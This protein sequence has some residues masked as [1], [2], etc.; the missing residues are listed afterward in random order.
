MYFDVA[1]VGGGAA[2]LAAAVKLK[3]L[4]SN[5]SV[6]VLEQ[7]DRVA[8]KL[9]TT[10][11]GQCNITNRFV[12]IEKYH[13][14]TEII[15]EVFEKYGLEY[16]LDFF[17]SIGVSITFK[18][19]GRAYPS[20][21]QASSV[22][23]ALRF[24]AEELGINIITDCAVSDIKSQNKIILNTTKGSINAQN[25]ILAAGLFSAVKGDNKA[26]VF[27]MLKSKGF[28]TQKVT[29]AIVQ[30]KTQ[31]QVVKQ[32]K[33]I[34][35]DGAVSLY[36]KENLIRRESGE[37]LFTD[38]GISG[39]PVLQISREAAIKQ[40]LTV[41]IDLLPEYSFEN[42]VVYLQKRR[43]LL[44]VRLTENFL[45]G[46]VNKRVGQVV[47]KLAEIDLKKQIVKL[48]DK[49]IK[50]IATLLK[51]FKLEATGTTGFQ[52]SQVSAG[53]ISV[54]EIDASMQTHRIKNL[55]IV[56]ELLNIDGDCGGYN[57][58]WAW[59]SAFAAAN[60]IARSK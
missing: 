37:I 30:I 26:S 36:N 59:S 39:P 25:V 24:S 51:R 54:S 18:E 32:L 40:N 19:D 50:E 13:G 21:Y 17:E 7:N 35:V 16:T 43:D 14:E 56:G 20:S 48:T 49:E 52:N 46:F 29:P 3:Q 55:Y 15:K 12:N 9:I 6:A 8:K 28:S 41:L 34:K 31:T 44:K 4:N 10:G 38:Y 22:V 45:N 27:E 11:N 42:L 1:I 53:G 58:Q 23:D 33:G 47:L 5:L 2:G 60:A 57:L